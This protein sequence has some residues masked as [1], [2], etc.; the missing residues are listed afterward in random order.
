MTRRG[1]LL[2]GATASLA[3][4]A[5]A[6]A[7]TLAEAIALAYGT[8]PQLQAAR[9]SQRA[10]DE[11]YVQARAGWGP[12]VGLVGQAYWQHTAFG[13]EASSVLAATG[14]SPSLGGAGATSTGS[15]VTST[16]T[17]T[18]GAEPS[19]LN[20]G[21]AAL[22]VSQPLYTGGK[23]AAE[24]SA[25]E[26]AVRAGR[27]SL[28]AT[29]ASVLAAVITA[30]QDVLRDTAI[31]RI[32]EEAVRVLGAQSD[33][34][35]AKFKVGQANR[36]DVCQAGAQRAAADAL[37]ASA[38]ADLAVSRAEYV[39]AVGQ[40]PA[41]LAEAPD[42]P[43]LPATVDAAFDAAEAG[44]PALLQA[45]LTETASRARVAAARANLRPTVTAQASY[46]AE[47]TL[48]PFASRDFD[49]VAT[50]EVIFTQPIFT[51]GLN[52]SLVRQ[53]LAQNG[54]DRVSIETTRRG[55]VQQVSQAWA[56]LAGA[57]ASLASDLTGLKAAQT[58]FDG[59][60]EEYRVG[61][62]TTLDVLIQQQTLESAELSVAS[63]RHDAYLA[64]ANL[65]S[66][67]GRLE[68]Q[69]LAAGTAT[70]DP[71]RN[72]DRVRAKG[73]TPWEPLVALVDRLGG[74]DPR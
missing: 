1:L 28:R 67:M 40:S 36:V 51:G 68:A 74:P 14:G 27:Q 44:S 19:D 65:L 69:D 30:Y 39:A 5:A 70:Y 23:V 42:L 35:S 48:Q 52:G 7:E 16:G 20:Y 46:G 21:Y 34:A 41:D 3:L 9:A 59:I 32:R 43:G 45:Q 31:L 2:A 56:T 72:F 17:T 57:R 63:A 13:R 66:A 55:V 73:A 37:V 12:T 10:L 60:R 26:A 15:A 25:A 24:V 62:T 33:E 22:S 71:S 4:G 64:Q 6:R 61:L 18:E 53:A 29:E 38:R 54:A 49:R 58:A 47:G 11:T 50:G 8:N